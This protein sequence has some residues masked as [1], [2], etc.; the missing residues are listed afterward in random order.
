MKLPMVKRET[1]VGIVGEIYSK[2][3]TFGMKEFQSNLEK[4]NKVLAEGIYDMIGILAEH[5]CDGDKMRLA[6]SC[7]VAAISCN[8]LYKSLE[9][10]LS[11]D[12]MND[13]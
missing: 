2:N 9:K 10:Q 7:T 8:L 5:M 6:E 12:E 3:K 4:D 13:E 11:I 1:L